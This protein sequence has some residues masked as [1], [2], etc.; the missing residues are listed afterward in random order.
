MHEFFSLQ[1]ADDDGDWDTDFPPL[2]HNELVLKFSFSHLALVKFENAQQN[3]NSQRITITFLLPNRSTYRLKVDSL[4][5]QL[6]QVITLL[7]EESG[8]GRKDFPVGAAATVG[9]HLEKLGDSNL[10]F[11]DLNIPLSLA[12][13]KEFCLV[14]NGA[15]SAQDVPSSSRVSTEL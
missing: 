2:D 10:K 8:W 15:K 9:Y 7:L 6:G 11:T 1:I 12:K 4:D 13:C 5:I 3:G 14:R